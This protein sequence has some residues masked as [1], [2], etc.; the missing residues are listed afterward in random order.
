MNLSSSLLLVAAFQ[1]QAASVT[2]DPNSFELEVGAT[3]QLNVQIQDDAGSPVR[4][5]S[6]RWFSRDPAVASVTQSGTVTAVNPGMVQIL[7]VSGGAS[8]AS[9]RGVLR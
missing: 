5:A 2:V 1:A 3:M 9:V 8:G 4:N 7:V 6:V